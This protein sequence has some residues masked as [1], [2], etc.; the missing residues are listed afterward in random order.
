MS[1]SCPCRRPWE[2]IRGV[3]PVCD[4]ADC[5]RCGRHSSPASPSNHATTCKPDPT[6]A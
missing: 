1:K 6:G 5:P 2:T 4:G 3:R